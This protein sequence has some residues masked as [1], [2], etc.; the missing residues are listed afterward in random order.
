MTSLLLNLLN[1]VKPYFQFTIL[2][3]YTRTG[4]TPQHTVS[5]LLTLIPVNFGKFEVLYSSFIKQNYLA[6]RSST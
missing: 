5:F 4:S 6:L 1:T 3:I 2:P